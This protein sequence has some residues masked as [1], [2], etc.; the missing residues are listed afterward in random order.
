MNDNFDDHFDEMTGLLFLEQQLDPNRAREVSSHLAACDHCRRLLHALES[1]NVWLRQALASDEEPVP[2]RLLAAT[3][4]ASTPWGWV[5]ALGLGLAGA[6]TLWAGFIQPWLAK[7]SQA[8]FTQSNI[9]T[10]LLFSGAFWRGWDTM[11]SLMELLA[12]GTLASVA[13]WLFRKQWRRQLGRPLVIGGVVLG[14]LAMGLALPPSAGATTE[15]GHGAPSYS[16]PAGHEVKGDL[17][18][19]A[20]RARIDGDVDGD[21][22]IWSQSVTINGHVKGDVLAMSEELRI[23][24][25]VDGNVRSWAQV[26]S[27]N[28]TVGKNISGW[29]GETILEDKASVGG[30]M[31]MFSGTSEING[32]LGGDLLLFS[33]GDVDIN[34]TLDK[35]AVL[36]A[37]QLTIGPTAEIKG[38]TKYEGRRQADVAASAKLGSPVEFKMLKRGPNYAQLGYYWHQ[39][40]LWGASFIFGLVVLLVAPGFFADVMA[41]AGKKVGPALGFGALFL[42]ATPIAAAI[43]CATIVGLGLGISAILLYCIAIYAT[44]VFIG[45]W[46]GE[47]VLGPSATGGAAIGRLALGLAILRVLRMLPYVGALVALAIVIWGLGAVVLAIYKRARPQLAPAIA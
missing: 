47:I 9:L 30:S 34:G 1:E 27:I 14:A 8:G 33:V 15:F 44:Q 24:G 7:A 38:Q 2:A 21:L 10:M 19:W 17:I 11:R 29:T 28:G 39:V 32:H 37:S 13:V 31:I 5:V 12:L 4:R 41:A 35:D 40:L 42:F 43:V 45:A 26:L 22:I 16:L 20:V 46:L 23:N 36:R 18:V 3:N 6:Y 25:P